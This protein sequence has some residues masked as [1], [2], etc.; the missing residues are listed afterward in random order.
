MNSQIELLFQPKLHLL[1][2]FFFSYCDKINFAG[3][4]QSALVDWTWIALVAAYIQTNDVAFIWSAFCLVGTA[5]QQVGAVKYQQHL[6]FQHT[7]RN[8]FLSR[9]RRKKRKII[10]LNYSAPA[11]M[12][13]K[14][15]HYTRTFAFYWARLCTQGALGGQVQKSAAPQEKGKIDLSVYTPAES[16]FH[17]SGGGNL[18]WMALAR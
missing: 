17:C 2:T 11:A 16:C 13:T 8:W 15:A 1:E 3:G 18:T 14:T 10:H 7:R 12:Q 4:R 6:N 9:R 5:P